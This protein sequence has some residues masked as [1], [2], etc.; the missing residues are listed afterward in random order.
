M[1]RFVSPLVATAGLT[2]GLSACD[3]RGGTGPKVEPV[4]SVEVSPS[5]DTVRV[6]ETVQLTATTKDA[7]GKV[8]SGRR[9]TWA[10]NNSPVAA[11]SGTGLVTGVGVGSTTIVATSEGRSG[12]ASVTV[13]PVPFA[14]VS[15]YSLHTCGLATGGEAY[16]WGR[17]MYGPL[18]NGSTV[19]KWVPTLVSGGLTFVSV[20]AGASYTCGVTTGGDAYCWGSGSD[21]RLGSGSTENKLVPT[22][23][24][25]ALTWAS[26]SAG[27]SHAC[28]V[29]TGGDAYCWGYGDCGKLGNGSTMDKRVPTMVSGG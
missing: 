11:V 12:T 22:L 5:S 3:D 21:G 8:L 1:R 2:L 26:V 18:G 20:S 15:A 23:V 4:A 25:G 24:S 7:E 10:S 17:A 9:I 13:P 29:T 28:G 19:D 16:C 14:A 6:G 27:V